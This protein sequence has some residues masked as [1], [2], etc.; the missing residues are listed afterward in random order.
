MRRPDRNV[1]L[2]A[3]CQAIFVTGTAVVV[4]VS[5]LVGKALADDPRLSTVPAG[6]QFL[7]A[8]ATTLPA[9]LL[10]QRFGR[11]PVFLAGVVIGAAGAAVC[12]AAIMAPSFGLFCAGTSLLGVL[13]GAAQYYRFA[14]AD[15]VDAVERPRAIAWVLAGGLLAAFVG[16]N[17]ASWTR[18]G[19]Q[20]PEFVGSFVA[21]ALL[22]LAS[23]LLLVRLELPA[24][25][26]DRTAASGRSV[27]RLLLDPR[28]ALAVCGAVVA[29]A[30]MSWLMTATPLAMAALGHP[31]PRTASVIQWHQV[32]MFAPAFVAGHLVQ[33]F[34][35]PRMMAAG[36]GL[37]AASATVGAGGVTMPHFWT[38][39]TGLGVGWS[40]LFV[41][42]T[43]LLTE[44]HTEG[45]RARAQGFND[46]LVFATLTLATTTAGLLHET[47]GWRAM[48]LAA[49]P[50]TVIVAAWSAAVGRRGR[51]A[52]ATVDG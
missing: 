15:A 6:L 2:L 20:G 21:L 52:V 18:H 31:F 19:L 29:Y 27:S 39:L 38:A 23:F 8:M 14:A 28:Y 41:A 36:A 32:G 40:F 17:L 22:Q 35:A 7:S 9:S 43:A 46:L 26:E 5:A 24:A 50:A 49:L 33:R 13:A 34:G 3:A 4:T 12:A 44:T 16:P 1:L 10:M 42:A 48:N 11:R 37:L 47:I 25:I 51:G 30:T 45:E